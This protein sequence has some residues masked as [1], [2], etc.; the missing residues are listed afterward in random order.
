MLNRRHVHAGL[1]GFALLG[2]SLLALP[3]VASAAA[4]SQSRPHSVAGNQALLE[5]QLTSRAAELARLSTDVTGATTLT[6]AHTAALKAS[7]ASA[8]SNIDTLIAKV[9]HDTTFAELKA[10]R[11]SMLKENRVFAVL[12]PQ[13]F[14][15]IEADGIGAQVATFQANESSLQGSVNSLVG[16]H[17]Y[18]NALHHYVAFVKAVNVA[19]EAAS[20]VTSAVLAQTPADYP[21]DTGIFVRSNR[22]LLK[23]DLAL[24][25]ASYDESVIGLASGGY[26][27]A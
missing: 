15:T 23:A 21:G 25:H 22:A 3:G 10:D 8:T 26:T 24:A 1:A 13:V 14:L 12:A 9:P 6:L 4:R 5:S 19:N 27:G 20:N 7:I 16:Q 18:T 17:G 2:G 11:A